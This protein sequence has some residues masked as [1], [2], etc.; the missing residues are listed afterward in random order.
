M[1]KKP[2]SIIIFIMMLF[3]SLA[4]E[5]CAGKTPAGTEGIETG[6]DKTANGNCD[7]IMDK[8]VN[9]ELPLDKYPQSYN[10]SI[11]ETVNGSVIFFDY[12]TSDLS[13]DSIRKL[14]EDSAILKTNPDIKVQIEGH[15]D[16]R[17]TVEYN[18]ALGERRAN[19]VKKYLVLMGIDDERLSI[20]SYGKEKP[21]DPGHNQEAWAKNRRAVISVISSES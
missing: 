8:D 12:D 9:R 15:C 4:L 20:I 5:G 14:N 18:L 13:Q 7:K 16:E 1:K 17:G 10:Q 19:A 2:T 3:V 11:I 21:A 6:K